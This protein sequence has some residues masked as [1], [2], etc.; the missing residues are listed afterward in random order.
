MGRLM[1]A[2][3][4]VLAL[5]LGL[6]GPNVA[7]AQEANAA[8]TAKAEPSMAGQWV[9]ALDLGAFK[10]RVVIHLTEAQG[11]LSGTWDSPDQNALGNPLKSASQSGP[12]LSL[13]LGVARYE[14]TL[15][16]D[17][18]T[19]S[20]T[21]FQGGARPLTFKRSNE[22][23][24]ALKR[25]QTPKP[26]Y[27]YEVKEVSF[28][29]GAGDPLSAT[30]TLPKGKGP[31]PVAILVHGS[32]PNDRDET[33]F[34]HKPFAVIA[35]HLTRQGIAVLRYDKRGVGKSKGDY[36]K[37]TLLDFAA[38]TQAAVAYVRTL[39]EIDGQKVGLIGHSEGGATV[40]LVAQ[41]DPS[42]A[43]VVLL[44]GMVAKGSDVLVAQNEAINR[45]MGMKESDV[46][47]SASQVRT[48]LGLAASPKSNDEVAKDVRA[49]IATQ[50]LGKTEQDAS[51]QFFS[52]PWARHLM[53]YD[54]VPALKT[55]K[56]PVLALNGSKDLQVL[57]DQNIPPLKAALAQNPKAEIEV[58]EGVNH[59]FQT[60]KTGAPVEYQ[61]IE[62]TITPKVLDRIGVFVKKA[63]N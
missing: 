25:P 40:P 11:K 54:P 60:A 9:G 23:V 63:V 14:G 26:P 51:A 24:A 62:E 36:A 4:L 58:V 19:V 38:D 1:T 31:F 8:A 49:F 13:D 45:A 6:S 15:S 35:D 39:P 52:S 44:A 42:I 17:G 3:I 20:G 12:K 5:A 47:L 21:F 61:Q 55:L 53:T 59:L 48:M 28:A 18:Q 56:M 7:R 34:E 41:K 37:A 43:Y 10:L 29:S 22:V 46:K 33:I 27:P 32:G 16:P 2:S 57:P 50:G 30:L